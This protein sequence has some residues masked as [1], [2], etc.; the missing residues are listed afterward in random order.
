[1]YDFHK[2]AKKSD[3]VLK[4]FSFPKKIQDY[5]LLKA[6][7]IAVVITKNAL[8]FF[9]IKDRKILRTVPIKHEVHPSSLGI[10]TNKVSYQSKVNGKLKNIYID[11]KGQEIKPFK[12]DDLNEIYFSFIAVNDPHEYTQRV[13]NQA[14]SEIG[15]NEE[16][17]AFMFNPFCV[18]YYPKAKTDYFRFQFRNDI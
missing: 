7:K 3:I 18:L 13:I 1:M 9:A 4:E 8:Y 5:Y 17:R 14:K 15:I 11:N 16:P 6:P 10:Y 2:I 12:E